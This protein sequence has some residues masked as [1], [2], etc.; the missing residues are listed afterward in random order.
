M[1]TVKKSRE[2]LKTHMLAVENT[3][4]VGTVRLVTFENLFV[5]KTS[6]SPKIRNAASGTQHGQSQEKGGSLENWRSVCVCVCMH[7]HKRCRAG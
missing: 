3:Q 7:A 6:A 5:A 1:E 4:E 2:G